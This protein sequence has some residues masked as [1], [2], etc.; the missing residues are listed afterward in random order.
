MTNNGI[1]LAKIFEIKIRIDWSWLL[2][3]LLVVWNLSA[4]FSQMHPDWSLPLTIAIAVSAALLFFLS[5]LL[6]ELAHSLVAKAQGIPVDSITLFLFGGVANIREEPKSPRNEFVMAILGPVTSLVIGFFLILIASIGLPRQQLLQ[7]QPM[8]IVQ[9]FTPLR[10]IAF[11]LGSINVVLGLFN[12]IPGFPLDG[13]RVL[14]SIL[15]ALTQNLRRA[16]RWASYV[17]QV[18]AWAMIISGI[19]MIFGMR[20]P[21]LGEGLVN[22]VWLIFIGWFLNNA[23]SRSY[24]QLMVRDILA[25]VPVKRMTK[26]NPPTVPGDITVDVLIDDYIMQTDDHAFPVMDGDRLMGIVCL[27]DIRRLPGEL[28]SARLVSEIMTPRSEIR[29]IHPDDDAYEALMTIS[30][31]SVRQLVV[32]DGDEMFG[33]VRRRDIIRF[34]QIQSEDFSTKPLIQQERKP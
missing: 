33:L 32:M 26:R 18:I 29:T 13:G 7:T 3:L 1:R 28:R 31:N 10:T 5:V 11:W 24:Q 14:R 4:A 15:W 21:Y 30:R 22:G 19:A 27:D 20:L 16:T 8:E 25:D 12:L 34:L 17:G 2:I 9:Q 6:H 23:A